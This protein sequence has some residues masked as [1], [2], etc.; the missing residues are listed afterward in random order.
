[1]SHNFLALSYNNDLFYYRNC[2]FTLAQ[3]TVLIALQIDQSVFFFWKLKQK[4]SCQVLF[5]S[6]T[7]AN[8]KK[9]RRH[10][11]TVKNQTFTYL[12]LYFL[13]NFTFWVSG[14]KYCTWKSIYPDTCT[15]VFSIL[16]TSLC[17][18]IF[19][20]LTHLISLVLYGEFRMSCNMS[21]CKFYKYK[22]YIK[23]H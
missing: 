6:F 22:P 21:I 9:K 13:C 1:M 20:V 10:T 12:S 2:C 17:Y 15:P 14:W 18:I 19:Y 5:D 11:C 16:F 7:S 4:L 3:K 23:L 8:V